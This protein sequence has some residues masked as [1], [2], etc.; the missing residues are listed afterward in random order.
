MNNKDIKTQLSEI[1]KK[2]E[3]DRNLSRLLALLGPVR[4]QLKI[5]FFLLRRRVDPGQ[6]MGN[7]FFLNCGL[8]F[9]AIVFFLILCAHL[10]IP[11][12]VDLSVKNSARF[13]LN[14]PGIEKLKEKLDSVP[15]DQS[16]FSS[17]SLFPFDGNTDD[18]PVSAYSQHEF[19]F[20]GVISVNEQKAVVLKAAKD[21]PDYTLLEGAEIKG[22][23]VK[24]IYDDKVV[25][26][27]D[28][29]ITEVS[30]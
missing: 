10:V 12:S 1:R 27:K 20:K 22:Y 14:D 23:Y 3:N 13:S 18:R 8:A 5:F 19:E 9:L 4:K 26:E 6:T 2:I 11:Y 28:G 24:E 17:R 15:F 7:F 16:I 30:K 29:I 21:G 25:L